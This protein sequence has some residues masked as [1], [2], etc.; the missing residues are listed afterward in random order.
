MRLFLPFSGPCW[1]FFSDLSHQR[2]RRALVVLAHRV[3]A[4]DLFEERSVDAVGG[5]QHPRAADVVDVHNRRLAAG[6]L[7]DKAR[8]AV[9]IF[10]TQDHTLVIGLNRAGM[11]RVD[12][13]HLHARDAI[14][15]TPAAQQLAEQAYHTGRQNPQG[16]RLVDSALHGGRTPQTNAVGYFAHSPP[17][18]P[19]QEA[20]TDVLF[21]YGPPLRDGRRA[22]RHHNQIAFLPLL[23]RIAVGK[24]YDVI[25][26]G[27]DFG[28]LRQTQVRNAIDGPKR[29]AFCSQ[30]LSSAL[31]IN[32]KE[33]CR[34][35]PARLTR[36]PCRIV[37]ISR[38]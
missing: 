10:R 37:A 32:L 23:V 5:P 17:Q 2:Y 28:L 26:G 34:H 31:R 12:N 22:F 36:R 11:G 6:P 33:N 7:G 29:L 3:V 38:P 9:G 25:A 14:K 18:Q 16:A 15:I 21:G 27:D 1:R 35:R 4:H 24:L 19:R 20:D 30:N 8:H 13:G